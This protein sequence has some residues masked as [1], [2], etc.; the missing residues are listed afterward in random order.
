MNAPTDLDHMD[1]AL[2]AALDLQVL[3]VAGLRGGPQARRAACAILDWLNGGDPSVS[4]EANL[5]L[6]APGRQHARQ[7]LRQAHRDAVLR[8]LWRATCPDLSPAVAG[9]FLATQWQRYATSAWPR[10][11]RAGTVPSATP[12]AVFHD[13]LMRGHRPLRSD[14]IRK[15]LNC[16]SGRF[17]PVERPTPTGDILS[18]KETDDEI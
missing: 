7:R 14:T 15:L 10:H 18:G 5:G 16:Q 11:Q 17:Q 13:L 1:G 8:R 2:D 6:S 9:R 4:L 12:D 3:A